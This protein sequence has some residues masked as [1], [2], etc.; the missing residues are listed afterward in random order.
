VPGPTP[1]PD[2]VIHALVVVAVQAQVGCVVTVIEPDVPVAGAVTPEGESAKVQLGPDSVTVNDF[3][4]IVSVAVLDRLPGFAITLKVTVPD[5]VPVVLLEIVTQA[6]L[7]DAAQ[8]QV[9]D[10]VIVTVPVPPLDGNVW[11]VGEIVKT[12]GVEGWV[13]ENVLSA[14]VIVPVRDVDPVFAATV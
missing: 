7:L 10:V 5:P 4:A 1:E 13:T 8:L 9:D 3:P 14:M 6:A 12:H 11:L 2:T